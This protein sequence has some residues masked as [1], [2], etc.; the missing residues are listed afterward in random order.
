M[1]FSA[2]ASFAVAAGTGL[3]GAATLSKAPSW[4]ELPL[5][6]IPFVFAAQQSVEGVLWLVLTKDWPATWQGALANSFAIFALAIWPVYAPLAA[7]LVEPN[8]GRRLAMTGLFAAGLIPAVYAAADI[9]AHPY[10]ACVIQN[11]ISY[12]NGTFYPPVLIAVYIACTTLPLI[13]SSHK[14]VRWFGA[15]VVMGL[16]VSTTFYLLTAISVWCFFAAAGSIMV[17][18]HFAAPA[19]DSRRARPAD[20]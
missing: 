3:A 7:G 6:S 1:C 8:H 15:L 16:A 10:G 5:A 11:S 14:A 13:M 4:R 9:A 19:R 2:G 12:S 20:G 17:Y 18:L